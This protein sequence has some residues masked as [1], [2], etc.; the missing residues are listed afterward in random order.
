MKKFFL[1]SAFAVFSLIAFSQ[2]FMVNFSNMDLD[3]G[4]NF[5]GITENMSIGTFVNDAWALGLTMTGAVEDDATTTNVD[6]SADATTGWFARY[7]WNENMY[8]SFTGDE[9]DLDTDGISLGF[10]YTM[11]VNDWLAVEPNISSTGG[12]SFDD[13][14]FGLSLGLRF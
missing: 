6:E 4:L 12:F 8:V 9:I 14:D 1:T 13:M 10:G 7:Y 2:G 3:D 5:D 11:M